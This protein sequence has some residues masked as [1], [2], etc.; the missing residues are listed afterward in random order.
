MFAVK[1]LDNSSLYIHTRFPSD[2]YK[3][4]HHVAPQVWDPGV[5]TYISNDY[6]VANMLNMAQTATNTTHLFSL[7]VDVLSI[8]SLTDISILL[9]SPPLNVFFCKW[10]S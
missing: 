8:K 4:H 7:K 10:A 9:F 3:L 1:I 5:Q 2:K 6:Q